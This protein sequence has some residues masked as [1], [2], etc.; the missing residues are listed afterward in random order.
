MK[1]LILSYVLVTLSWVNVGF[2]EI[3]PL[4]LLHTNDFHAWL[5]PDEQGRG[6]AAIIAGYYKNV[7]AQESN[8]L[9]LDAGDMISGTPISSLFKGDPIYRVLNHWGIDA[10]ALGN[11]DFDY[12]W[13]RMKTYREIASFP[14]LCANAFVAGSDGANHLLADAEYK[15]FS[16]G[17][18]RV[19]VIGVIAEWTPTMTVRDAVRDVKFIPSID[20]LK[21]LVPLVSNQADLV[22]VLS[23]VGFEHDQKI[24]KETPDIDLIIGGHSHTLLKE[25]V[26]INDTIIVQAGEKGRFVGRIDLEADTAANQ[27]V[28]FTYRVLPVDANL[29]PPDPDTEAIVRE[30]ENK[31][32]EVVDHP[33]GEATE[34][35]S[36]NDMILLA[37]LAFL[38]A[39]GADYAFH[40]SGGTRGGLPQ[41]PFTSRAIWN[42][43]PFENTL[44]TTR[45]KG[46]KIPNGF[47][48]KSPIEPDQE[49]LIVTN[50]FVRDQWMQFFPKFPRMDWTDTGIDMR[51]SVMRHIEQQKKIGWIRL[52]R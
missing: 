15:I 34:T 44:L 10:A 8:V 41:G 9:I 3:V 6:G 26:K 40:N 24:A 52:V 45:V 27:F 43:F 4:T 23:H 30:W 2:A 16:F 33:L 28:G 31:V 36:K 20:T 11:H 22:V 13:Q 37:K 32:S 49:Y 39:T 48:G 50:S 51:D 38:E 42:L 12:G 14:F 29:S 46:N 18:L 7:R 5:L 1:R 35:L 21:R 19:G 17:A 25:F 47:L